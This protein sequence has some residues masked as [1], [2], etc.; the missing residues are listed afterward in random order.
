MHGTSM[1][2]LRETVATTDKPRTTPVHSWPRVTVAAGGLFRDVRA[3]AE[4][5]VRAECRSWS[6]SSA[7]IAW[8]SCMSTA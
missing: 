2:H 6:S 1:A 8:R 3:V 4:L 7:R 5:A